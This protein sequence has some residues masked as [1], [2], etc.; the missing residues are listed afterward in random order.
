MPRPIVIALSLLSPLLIAVS[1]MSAAQGSA[2]I[3][4]PSGM[5]ISTNEAIYVLGET[6]QVTGQVQ[7]PLDLN[8]LLRI[9]IFLPDEEI[10]RIDEFKI[11]NDGRFTWTF[12]LPA[13]DTGQWVISARFSTIEA[14]TT[15]TVLE[16]DI[17]D[18]VFMDS[19]ALLDVQRNEI[20]SGEGKFGENIAITATLVND[21]QVSHSFMFIVQIIN[22]DGA[23]DAVLLTLGSLQPGESIN[24]S[25]SW[26]PKERGAYTAEIFVW[27]SLNDPT[28]LVQKQAVAFSVT[29]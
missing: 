26:L 5:T 9:T 7:P 6:V 10:F 28:P 15:I 27:S 17:F 23:V 18:K 12:N 1:Q 16:T 4:E 8:N 14:E 29:S 22:K 11:N 13:N 19:P 21:E 20:T 25:V 3:V 2:G 24:P